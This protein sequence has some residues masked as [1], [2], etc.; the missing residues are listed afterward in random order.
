MTSTA[1]SG[2]YCLCFLP[3]IRVSFFFPAFSC[4]LFDVRAL[5]TS[6]RVRRSGTEQG[7]WAQT[8]S[9]L[10]GVGAVAG[11]REMLNIIVQV[12]D[13]LRCGA[14]PEGAAPRF[15]SAT[16]SLS[17]STQDTAM[18]TSVE[19]LS[20]VNSD[21]QYSVISRSKEQGN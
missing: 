15:V 17:P 2:L 8:P 20:D 11:K 12:D 13:G 14:S 18:T 10:Q 9:Q 6:Q 16:N 21:Q 5:H 3:E 4:G 19:N 7:L 1:T